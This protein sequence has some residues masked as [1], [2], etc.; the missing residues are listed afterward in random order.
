MEKRVE[1]FDQPVLAYAHKN[2]TALPQD[3]DVG[4]ALEWIRHQNL[5]E[6]IIYFYVIND[7]QQLV[8]VLPTRRLLAATPDRKISE[9]MIKRVVS[10]PQNATVLDACE[11]FL[12][13]KFLAFPVIDDQCHILGVVD[14]GLFTE[15][16]LDV[17]ESERI[18]DVFQ[19]IGFRVAEVQRASPWNSFRI[20][21][22][23]L[24]ATMSGGLVC[25]FLSGAY[26]TTLARTI[27]LAFFLAL[28]LGLGESVSVQSLTL[29]LQAL[30]GQTITWNW[31]MRIARKE[32]ATAAMLGG[33]SGLLV[34]L[35]V[36]VWRGTGMA[37]VVIG[38]S[39]LF[40]ITSACL[41]GLIVPSVLHRFRLDPRIAAGPVAL[42]I[43][44]VVTLLFY[45]NIARWV[46]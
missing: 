7:E 20:R 33:A 1:H 13:Y 23:W 37:A 4:A 26:E 16:V 22:P 38:V 43:A 18:S 31:F 25:A 41:I 14:V 42:A 24:L 44:D 40:A 34:G 30:H 32:L 19:T 8:G 39:L 3:Y 10:I 12:L 36:Y 11:Q 35:V 29:T 2:F 27:V 17:S 46:L 45:F 5:A 6:R 21:F 9:V 28:V 15:E